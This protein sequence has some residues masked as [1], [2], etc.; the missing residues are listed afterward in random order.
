MNN[1]EQNVSLIETTTTDKG[2]HKDLKVI[3]DYFDLISLYREQ[4]LKSFFGNSCNH[5]HAV[6]LY[7]K[8]G[9]IVNNFSIEKLPKFN[10]FGKRKNIKIVLFDKRT[11]DVNNLFNYENFEETVYLLESHSSSLYMYKTTVQCTL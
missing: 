1:V 6:V 11:L 10:A 7:G 4:E 3:P 2:N 5:L 9:T 8:N